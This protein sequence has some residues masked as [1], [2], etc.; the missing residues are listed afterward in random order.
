MRST[1]VLDRTIDGDTFVARVTKLLDAG[2]YMEF[3][4]QFNVIVRIRGMN[5]PELHKGTVAQKAEGQIAWSY[6]DALL[7]DRVLLLTSYKD[8]RS[9]ER[10]VCDVEVDGVPTGVIEAGKSNWETVNVADEMIA[11]GLAAA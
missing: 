5:A 7:R 1:A 3:E 2:F 11:C 9:F 4:V 10:W 8:K 6:L